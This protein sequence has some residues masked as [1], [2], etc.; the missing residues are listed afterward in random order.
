MRWGALGIQAVH[1]PAEE[2]G[3]Q[4]HEENFQTHLY[5]MFVAFTLAALL[6]AYFVSKLSEALRERERSLAEAHERT[7]RWGK[8]ASL[9]TLAAGA[10]HELGTPMATIAIA[11]KEVE[12]R[13]KGRC[14]LPFDEPLVLDDPRSVSISVQIG[15]LG[16]FDGID[17]ALHEG[18]AVQQR[19]SEN[20]RSSL[21]A[22]RL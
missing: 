7:R 19:L 18:A 16:W 11:A 22:K 12:R 2:L 20:I 6:I 1:A 4:G 17:F 3:H 10:A 5:G 14:E 8:H 21:V 15:H 9:A 13:A